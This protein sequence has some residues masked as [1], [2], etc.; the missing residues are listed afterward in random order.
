MNSRHLT[1]RRPDMPAPAPATPTGEGAGSS[2]EN[3]RGEE[4]GAD[5][6]STAAGGASHS[7]SPRAATDRKAGKK[8]AKRK[9]ARERK[10]AEQAQADAEIA[11]AGDE[12]SGKMHPVL[13]TL[14]LVER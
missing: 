7:P 2:C 12:I 10:R 11:D 14:P 8:N 13:L 1:H 3:P 9:A 6:P 4:N 5:T